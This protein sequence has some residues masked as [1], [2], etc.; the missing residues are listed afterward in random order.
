MTKFVD[1]PFESKKIDSSALK[2]PK[3]VEFVKALQYS[4]FSALI[5]CRSN[6]ENEIVV[7]DCEPEVSQFPK[8]DIRYVERL[9]AV[10]NTMDKYP[11]EVYALREDFPLVTHLNL[12]PFEV[13]R[14]LCLY[15]T[16][17]DELKISWRGI[18]FLERIREWLA[19]TADDDLHQI[20]QPLEPF[21]LDLVGNII[22]PSGEK[23]LSELYVYHIYKS[24]FK[25]TFIGCEEQVPGWQEF[26]N[27]LVLVGIKTD[28][29]VHGMIKKTPENLTQLNELVKELGEDLIEGAILPYISKLD[30]NDGRLDR[31]LIIVI[32]VPKKRDEKSS[33][34]FID[35]FSF[36]TGHSVKDIGIMCGLWVEEMGLVVDAIPRLKFEKKKVEQVQ[37]FGLA[38]YFHFNRNL[39]ALFNG[40]EKVDKSIGLIGAGALGSQVYVNL[41][42]MGVGRWTV[43]DDDIL[44]P[45][46]LARHDLTSNSVGFPKAMSMVIKGNDL[47]GEQIDSAIIDNYLNPKKSQSLNEALSSV[48]VILDISAST[49]VAR[50]LSNDSSTSARSIS[51]FLN[52]KGSDL[53]MLAEPINRDIKLDSLE[54]QYY[55]LLYT[56]GSLNEH[57]VTENNEIRY[58]RSC[59]DI[60]SKIMQEDVSTFSGIG[61]KAIRNILNEDKGKISIWQMHES[62]KVDF[63]DQH[64]FEVKERKVE[65]WTICWDTYLENKIISARKLKLPNETGGILLGMH[66]MHRKKIY[67]VD[68]ILSP[69]DSHEYP[70]AYYR[71]ILGLKE[72]L[73]NI[74]LITA[75]NIGYAGEWHSHPPKTSTEMSTDDKELLA[76]IKEHM[77]S[78][79]LPGLMLIAGDKS[80]SL[81]M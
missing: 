18:I 74:S 26:E 17:Y 37:I 66:D 2:I 10:F 80:L 47:A 11:P 56:E 43:I 51:L 50:K 1:L 32:S 27:N 76:W 21:L 77:N 73:A 28:P 44:L 36:I 38:T 8:N 79:G 12:R 63:I 65:D 5:E 4:P 23:K 48:D 75:D 45:H 57:L 71:G 46:N 62:G 67:L 9:A 22:L 69:S 30:K 7:F 64:P 31:K 33:P 68:T 49:A 25:S 41:T 13:P 6:E 70:H 15:E 61:S 54:A 35:H 60:S 20:D 59:R 72:R 42:R 58:S 55:R 14:S 24:G 39:A 29:Q 78:V 19:L 52:S 40:I 16:V 81:Y 3:A 34:T 53:V